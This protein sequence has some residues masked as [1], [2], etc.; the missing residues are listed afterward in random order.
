MRLRRVQIGL[1]LLTIFMG[2]TTLVSS[3]STSSKAS[4]RLLD[5][6][7]LRLSWEERGARLDMLFS[8]LGIYKEP[9]KETSSTGYVLIY[10]GKVCRYGEVESHIRGIELKMSAREVPRDRIKVFA[11]GYREQLTIEL[12]VAPDGQLAPT[13]RPTLTIDKVRFTKVTKRIVEAYDCCDNPNEVWE[14]YKKNKRINL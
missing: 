10:C 9:G 8:E 3:Q 12:W 7:G 14:D 4:P 6:F 5:E 13:P 1:T 11:A 2:G